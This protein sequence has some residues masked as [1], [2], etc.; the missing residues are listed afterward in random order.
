MKPIKLTM[1]AFGPYAAMTEIDFSRLGENGVFLITGDTGAGKTTVFD[2]IS[3]ALYGEASG[4]DKRRGAKSFR[5]DYADASEITYVEYIFRHKEKTY[6][7]KRIPEHFRARK[8]GQGK[9]VKQGAEA[10]FE[11]RETGELITGLDSVNTRVTEIIGLDRGQF[12]N[13]VMIAQGDFLRILNAKSE[14]RK[15]IFQ[16]IFST[17]LY[18][19]LQN[20]LKE[21]NSSCENSAEL[22]KSEVSL[23]LS[24]VRIERD[25]EQKDEL[26]G[27]ISSDVRP[28]KLI[29]IIV[30]LTEFEKQSCRAL[31]KKL[32]ELKIESESLVAEKTAAENIAKDQ[33]LFDQTKSAIDT[34]NKR[35]EEI[36]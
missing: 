21:K 28:D 15:L 14:E 36:S 27:G 4:G 19:E 6:R 23:A 3:F 17:S 34:L 22:I 26:S 2:G 13:T 9:P 32:S 8:V 16:K 11:C 25:F 24:R 12:A 20:E 30:S 31:E 1:N 35:A 33:M 29:P 7:V 10:E 18:A 5:S